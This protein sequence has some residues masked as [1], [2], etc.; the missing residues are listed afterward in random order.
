VQILTQTV[1]LTSAIDAYKSFDE[2]DAGWVKV[3]L[4]PVGSV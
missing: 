3:K 1:P 4:E 2:R